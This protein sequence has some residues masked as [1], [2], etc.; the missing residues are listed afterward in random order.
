MGRVEE[1]TLVSYIEEL[2]KLTHTLLVEDNNEPM[3]T[4][5]RMHRIPFEELTYL[6]ERDIKYCPLS[7]NDLAHS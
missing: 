1:H 6:L 5:Q 3:G 2:H 4:G 7:R